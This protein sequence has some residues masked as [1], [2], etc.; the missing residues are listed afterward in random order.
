[1]ELNIERE[2]LLKPLQQVIGVVERRQ[3]LPI[4]GNVLLKT[5]DNELAITAT[6]LEIEM[7]SHVPL[8]N[9][10][11]G[12]TTLPARKFI[13]ICKAL[14][15][16]AAL[17]IKLEGDR[18]ILRSGKSRFV[19]STLPASEFPNIDSFD[20]LV[21]FEISQKQLKKLIDKTSFAM[22]QQD[23]RYYLNGLLFEFSE[24]MIRV[25]ATDGH[26]LALSDVKMTTGVSEL[27][28]VIVPR[29]AV[30]E[31]ARLLENSD[32]MVKVQLGS[33]HMRLVTGELSFI[34]KLIDGRFPDYQ[35]VVPQGG[36]KI[37]I[38]DR[39]LIHQALSRASILS[40]EKYRSVRFTL[41][42]GSLQVMANNPEQEEAEEEISVDYDGPTLEIGFNASY[43]LDALNVIGDENVLLELTDQNSCCLIKS[44]TAEESRY[45]V[46]PMRL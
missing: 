23:V 19:L 8:Q 17:T 7:M 4:L 33:N 10:E 6:D 38:A 27:Q 21:E 14:P 39:N 25:V 41:S 30:M 24:D 35:R 32:A 13:D 45:V 37:V 31:L 40:N 42:A 44:P 2:L 1:M 11:L 46:M 34:T 5:A 12:E 22:A 20:P 16:D 36:D 28:Q 3:T 26:R 18:A 15:N 29:K 9:S 43:I